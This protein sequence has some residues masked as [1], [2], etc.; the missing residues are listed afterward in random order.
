[1]KNSLIVFVKYPE[2]GRVKTRLA[3][4]IGAHDAAAVY[5]RLVALTIERTVPPES[6]AYDRIVYADPNF[7]LDRYRSWL[8]GAENLAIQQGDSLG[9]RM[10]TAFL[11]SFAAGYHKVALVGS[12][13]PDVNA[14]LIQN[15]FSLLD[16]CDAVLG[17]AV[18]GGYYLIALTRDNEQIFKGIDWGTARVM[19]QTI[20]RLEGSGLS[21]ALLPVLRDVDRLEDLNFFRE[22]GYEL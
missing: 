20:A 21:R 2:P 15:A 18:D 4:G 17:P 9:E 5:C 10:R 14:P 1:M 8:P 13:C 16:D 6:Q 12:D 11:E 3:D 19:Q 22:R 7:P